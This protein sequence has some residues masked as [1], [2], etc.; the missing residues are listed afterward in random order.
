M[1]FIRHRMPSPLPVRPVS[2]ERWQAA[3]CRSAH[4]F[5]N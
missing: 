2:A 1:A 4:R 3:M 5:I